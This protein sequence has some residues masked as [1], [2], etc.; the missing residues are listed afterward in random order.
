MRC[1]YRFSEVS[2]QATQATIKLG[3]KSTLRHWLAVIANTNQAF[4][5]RHEG[6]HNEKFV[7]GSR[8][9]YILIY[10]RVALATSEVRSTL[11]IPATDE[12]HMDPKCRL[13][14]QYFGPLQ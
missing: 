9:S 5:I 6:T 12:I 8:M 3:S 4:S 11:D 1:F 2:R 14:H 10:V 7:Q 13:I